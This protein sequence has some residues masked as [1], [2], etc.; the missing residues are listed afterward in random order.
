MKMYSYE[1]NTQTTFST[2]R[3]NTKK[4][5]PKNI[6]TIAVKE[7]LNTDIQNLNIPRSDTCDAIVS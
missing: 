1:I 6:Q 5:C 3:F 7:D 2:H 4:F